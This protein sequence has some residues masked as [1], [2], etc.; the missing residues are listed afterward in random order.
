L[1]VAAVI[2]SAGIGRRMGSDIHKPL[3]RIGDKPILF[4]T[5]RAFELSRFVDEVIVVAHLEDM[6]PI[7]RDVVDR[8]SIHKVR[9]VVEGGPERQDSVY[10]GLKALSDPP[11]MVVIH[12][13]VR[14]LVPVKLIDRSVELCRTRE[15]VIA[16]VPV[17]F[18]VKRVRH[19]VVVE[20][21]DRS[22]L[23]EIQTPQVFRYSLILEAH[24]RAR[25]DGIRATDDAALVERLGTPVS[26]I[27]G[28]RWNL[29]ITTPEDLK[30]AEF[31]L[32]EREGCG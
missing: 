32:T 15:A 12:D 13:A 31:L 11:D 20:T 30:L 22:E 29:K 9:Q 5:L 17:P 14:P 2:P 7:T 23:W 10:L 18:T 26:V 21:V 27:P 3:L 19:D 6:L 4:Y 24:E 25:A 1:R 28:S 16:G 8:Y